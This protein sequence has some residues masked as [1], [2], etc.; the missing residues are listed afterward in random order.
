MVRSQK[1]GG[2]CKYLIGVGFS[3]SLLCTQCATAT[4]VRIMAPIERCVRDFCLRQPCPIDKGV[5]LTSSNAVLVES[6][7][8]RFQTHRWYTTQHCWHDARMCGSLV[9]IGPK[10]SKT[11]QKQFE[12]QARDMTREH[13]GIQLMSKVGYINHHKLDQQTPK[14]QPKQLH[15]IYFS[16]QN[17]TVIGRVSTPSHCVYCPN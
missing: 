11:T 7:V 15:L 3:S 12:C 2:S 1:S 9:L 16:S 14:D 5:F 8:A 17:R 13:L 4:K 6:I 10:Q